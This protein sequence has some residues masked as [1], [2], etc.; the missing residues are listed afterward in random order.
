MN[1]NRLFSALLAVLLL[2][3]AL[4]CAA[5][6]EQPVYILGNFAFGMPLRAVRALDTSGAALM[7]TDAEREVQR[8][9]LLSDNFVVIL[10]FLGLTD[11][12]ALIEMDFAFFTSPDTVILRDGRLE[13]QT[14]KRTVN[15]VY[16]YVEN[17]CKKAFGRGKNA[18]DNSLPFSALLFEEA[19]SPDLTRLR[20]YTLP[21]GKK[22]DMI[23]HLIATGDYSV[24]Y[25]ICQ[26]SE[27]KI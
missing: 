18:A 24:N 14:T 11:E 2:C 19:D 20:I 7:E 23:V 17:L 15:P 26:Q 16:A 1:R 27:N 4:P 3:S 13:I 12:A 6:E 21:D 8:L 5:G 9:S 10:W 22:T 25:I